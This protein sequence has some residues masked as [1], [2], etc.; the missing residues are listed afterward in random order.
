M[1]QNPAELSCGPE[2]SGSDGKIQTQDAR[3]SH[4]LHHKGLKIKKKKKKKVTSCMCETA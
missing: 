4:S 3:I 1:E 2:H